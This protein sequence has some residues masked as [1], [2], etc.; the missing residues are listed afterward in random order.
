MS[1]VNDNI[2]YQLKRSDENIFP[3]EFKH[4]KQHY[5]Y[6]DANTQ[7][8]EQHAAHTNNPTAVLT[9]FI[10]VINNPQHLL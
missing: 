1:E 7:A 4:L 2:A 6:K 3:H 10:T 5:L 9:V 8:E